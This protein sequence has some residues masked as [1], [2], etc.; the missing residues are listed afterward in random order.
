MSLT[1]FSCQDK[2]SVLPEELLLEEGWTLFSSDDIDAKGEEIS[3]HTFKPE[4]SYPTDVP[5]TVLATLVENKVYTDIHVGDNF[6]KIPTEPFQVPWWY[7]KSFNINKES[8]KTNRLIF[9]GINYRANVWLNG[10]IIA[11][12][13]TME[14]CFRMFD[15]D[16]SKHIVEG[17]NILA[18]EVIPP[19]EKELTIGFV[20]WNPWPADNNLGLWRPVKLVRSGAVAIKNLYVK[21]N[22]NTET[23]K[24]ASLQISAELYNY[25][26]EKVSG[27]FV[28]EIEDIKIN[29]SYSIEANSKLKMVLGPENYSELNIE[30]P[31]IWWPHHLGAPNLYEIKATAKTGSGITDTKSSRFGIRSVEDYINDNGHRGYIVNGEKILIKGGGWVDDV[32]LDDDDKKIEAQIQ[33][34]KN[35]NMN[36][37]RLE[38]FWGRNK[39][40]YDLADEN[41]ILV[42]IGWSCQWEWEGYCGRPEDETYMSIFTPEDVALHSRSYMDQVRWL[43]NHPSVF[44]WVFG[45]DK[46]VIPELEKQLIDFIAEEDGTRP[47]LGACK[48]QTSELTGFTAVKMLGPYKYVTPNYWYL[49]TENGGAYGF[50]TETGPGCQP[51]PLESIKKMIPEDKLWPM[52]EIWDYHTGRNEFATFR[53]WIKPFNAR[54]GEAKNVEEFA[55]KAQLSNYEA[56]RAM[57]ESFAVNKHDATG[58][59]Q[60]MLNSA[61]PNMLWQVYDWYLMPTGA[62]YGT[63][64]ACEPLNLVYNYKDKSIYLTNELHSAQQQ[65]TA[66][67]KVLDLNSKVILEKE[68]NAEVAEN[69]AARIFDIP[70]LNGLTPVYFLDLKLKDKDGKQLSENFYWLSNKED[71]L[72]F[73]KTEWHLTPNSQYADFSALDKL[74]KANVEISHEFV[75]QGEKQEIKVIAKNSSYKLAFFIELALIDQSTGETVLPTFWEDNYISLLPGESKEIKGFVNK[76]DLIGAPGFRYQGMNLK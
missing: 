56:I 57:F 54:Y 65:L 19:K 23:L 16:V 75:A 45:S 43:R 22:L 73:E 49:D 64:H 26:K 61:V 11:S 69:T 2:A 28:C 9:E 6:S 31:R 30:N 66:E 50:N 4:K 15:F 72:D 76:E 1:I 47:T 40:I 34:V 24:Q 10:Q 46:L 51:P 74:P 21:P 52:N 37:I 60:W 5:S 63:M 13:D 67:I 17:E 32:L 18:V 27:E 41:G 12:A 70:A 3:S 14:G 53:D 59:I 44:L 33:Y 36:T 7:R 42:M 71:I 25:S 58:V 55:F 68:V 38:G 8:A 20:D 29:Q 62:F 35:M 48:Y 39:K